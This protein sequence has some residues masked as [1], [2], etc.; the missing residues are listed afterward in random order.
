MIDDIMH[1]EAAFS[2]GPIG[3]LWERDPEAQGGSLC[4]NLV[5]IKSLIGSKS[6]NLKAF[7]RQ[8]A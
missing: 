2:V 6:N 3:A 1:R 8:R 7:D 5:K 4:G